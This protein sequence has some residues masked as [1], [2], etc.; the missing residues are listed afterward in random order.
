MQ[1]L[2][3]I[4]GR[5]T[6]YTVSIFVGLWFIPLFLFDS[7]IIATT[8]LT[9]GIAFPLIKKNWLLLT[10]VLLLNPFSFAIVPAAIDYN[11]GIARLK[12]MGLPNIEY[13][14]IDPETRYTR[15]TG[16]CLINGNEWLRDTPYNMTVILLCKIFGWQKGSYDGPYPSKAEALILSDRAK[17]VPTSDFINGTIRVNGSGLQLTNEQIEALIHGLYLEFC[18]FKDECKKGTV[19]AIV[20]QDRCL[21]LRIQYTI[22][23]NEKSD[24]MIFFDLDNSRQFAY[25]NIGRAGIITRQHPISYQPRDDD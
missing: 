23:S 10:L 13:Y 12:G 9:M 1:K 3:T 24:F 19:S 11:Q 18:I 16:G 21:I 6:A 7:F 25:F 17:I 14:N 22:R 5:V 15:T 2:R 4:L 8:S 20:Y